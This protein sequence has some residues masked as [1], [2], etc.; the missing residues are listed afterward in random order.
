MSRW[1]ACPRCPRCPRDRPDRHLAGLAP[2]AS[3]RPQYRLKLGATPIPF[4]ALTDEALADMREPA[5]LVTSAASALAGAEAG[6]PSHH[7]LSLTPCF[8]VNAPARPSPC[9]YPH[10]CHPCVTP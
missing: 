8:R 10:P 9:R 2:W 7:S 3:A 1:C 5:L 4:D 6:H